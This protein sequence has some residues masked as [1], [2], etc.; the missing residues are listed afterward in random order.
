[1]TDPELLAVVLQ[2]LDYI[3]EAVAQHAR[4]DRAQHAAVAEKID[5]KAIHD[6]VER[7]KLGKKIDDLSSL[8]VILNAAKGLRSIVVS[9][10][11]LAVALTAI[12]VAV[13]FFLSWLKG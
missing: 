2:R 7:A 9:L 6:T 1:M 4:D 10:G 3:D 5:L 8:L 13:K 12:G 11:G